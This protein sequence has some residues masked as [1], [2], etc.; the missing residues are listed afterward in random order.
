MSSVLDT[1]RFAAVQA[2]KADSASAFTAYLASMD[3]ELGA[4]GLGFST[5][6][7]AVISLMDPWNKPLGTLEVKA[8]KGRCHILLN[9][10]QVGFTNWIRRLEPGDYRLRI[11][12]NGALL[13]ST[14]K[15]R[16]QA[17]AT[18]SVNVEDLK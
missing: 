18:E 15:L 8:S 6:V 2:G 4:S 16:I 3:V 7:D 12:R 11:V 9:G 10:D 17:G 1:L 14:D 5:V 13:F